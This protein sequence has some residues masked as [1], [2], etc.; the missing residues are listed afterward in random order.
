MELIKELPNEIHFDVIKF[1]SH[2]VADLMKPGTNDF[3]A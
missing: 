2:A 1:M 3:M